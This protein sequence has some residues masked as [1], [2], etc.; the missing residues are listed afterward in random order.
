MKFQMGLNRS[1]ING[2][3][4]LVLFCALSLSITELKFS[5]AFTPIKPTVAK[6]QNSAVQSGRFSFPFATPLFASS[7][8][9]EAVALERPKK[10]FRLPP[11]PEDYIVLGGD[12][13]ALFTYAFLDHFIN[14]LIL[15]DAKDFFTEPNALNIPVWSDVISNNFGTSLLSAISAQQQI[16][17]IGDPAMLAEANEALMSAHHYAPCLDTFGVSAVLLGTCWLVSGYFNRAFEYKNTINC[18]PSHAIVVAGRTWLFTAVMMV[19][20]AI[21]SNSAFCGCHA[22]AHGLTRA[23]TDFIFDSFSVLVTWRFVAVTLLGGLL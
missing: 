9:E 20:L 10:D 21:W 12:L 2:F 18:H 19:G 17:D 13:A 14:A 23:D 6:R 15:A 16:A 5:A 22:P 11:P 4:S 1:N 8:P 7:S 3:I